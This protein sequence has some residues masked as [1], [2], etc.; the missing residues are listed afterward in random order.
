MPRSVDGYTRNAA[1]LHDLGAGNL[2]VDRDRSGA[3]G[4]QLGVITAVEREVLNRQLG[5]DVECQRRERRP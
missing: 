3:Q 1:L 4:D 5:H 2:R